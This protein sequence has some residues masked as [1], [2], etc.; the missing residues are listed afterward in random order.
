LNLRPPGYEPGE[1]PDC[2][3]PRRGPECSTLVTINSMWDWAV[4]GA[5][6]VT[7]LAGVAALALVVVRS[8]RAWHEV[9]YTG[10][11]TVRRLDD[12]TVKAEA[13]ADRLETAGDMAGLQ[14]SLARLRISL[15]RLAVLR[16]ALD[17]VQD[18]LGRV[19]AVVP[20]K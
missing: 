15:A 8:R 19:A 13:T 4:W 12:L 18:G 16:D 20:R 2:S 6:I 5:L 1:L 11:D 7:F 14:E 10:R 17:D 9:R 3:T